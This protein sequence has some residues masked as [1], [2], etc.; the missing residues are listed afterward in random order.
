MTCK[1][2]ASALY[3]KH[4]HY[5]GDAFVYLCNCNGIRERDALQVIESG[6]STVRQVFE[7]CG[8]RAQ[9]AKC[10]CE[11]RDM[12]DQADFALAIAAE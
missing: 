12:L 5:H 7:G 6:A 9:C 2:A 10:V 11:I 4:S 3:E 8:G 1:R